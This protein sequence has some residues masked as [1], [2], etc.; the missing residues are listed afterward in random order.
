MHYLFIIIKSRV[1][2]KDI[3][4]IKDKREAYKFIM[5]ANCWRITLTKQRSNVDY[6][7]NLVIVYNK[8]SAGVAIIVKNNFMKGI[9]NSKAN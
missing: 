1:K 9:D 2:V 3:F 7:W 5:L 4:E 6:E 8:K